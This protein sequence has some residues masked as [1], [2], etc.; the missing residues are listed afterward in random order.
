MSKIKTKDNIMKEVKALN[1]TISINAANQIK[2]N[3]NSTETKD[4]NPTEYSNNKI[5]NAVK[6]LKNK[7]LPKFKF[8]FTHRKKDH[9]RV[10][11]KIFNS[12]EQ[13]QKKSM[14]SAKKSLKIVK[15]ISRG[16]RRTVIIGI[17]LTV[18]AIKLF[19]KLVTVLGLLCCLIIF[20]LIFLLPASL[21]LGSVFGIFVSSE[22]NLEIKMSS[23]IAEVNN[24]MTLKISEIQNSTDG[25]N[26]YKIHSNRTEW[27]DVLIIYTVR[28]FNDNQEVVTLND[29][30]IVVLKEVF[31]DMNTIS[32][33][34]VD[35]LIDGNSMTQKKV[36][37][38][39]IEGKSVEEMQII[40]NFSENQ[41]E[42]VQELS[43]SQYDYL[44]S[45]VI[46]GLPLD[47]N[48]NMVQIAAS[49]VGNVGGEKFWR[50]YGFS[51]RVEWCAIFVSW[52]ADQAGYI[53][54]NIFPKFSVVDTGIDWFKATGAW[55]END[56]I[57]KAGDIIFF[58][59]ENDD[60]PNH[61]GIVEKVENGMIYTI[62]G[63][64]DNDSCKRKEYI[65][66]SDV[67][68]GYGVPYY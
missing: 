65:V 18:Q 13:A 22:S 51:E 59:W 44:W 14:D 54:K 9:T 68:Y 16:A 40:Y 29:E 38:I 27:K 11:E 43:D 17:A 23:V 30:K 26:E 60:K 3:I 50:W 39:Y 24:E 48:N 19:I 15:E 35:E 66:G 67:I 52:V 58:D 12:N 31:W 64:S 55:R 7:T 32:Y 46:Y 25:Y 1:R 4:N 42:Q 10:A 53:D 5:T 36:L 49:Q 62:E 45:N 6:E 33:E 2:K 63:N 37:H 28:M 20:L 57:P 8:N 21:L 61:V 41:K 56:Y 47:A 34:V